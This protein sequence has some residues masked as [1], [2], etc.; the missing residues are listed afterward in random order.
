MALRQH[1]QRLLW[2]SALALLLALAQADPRD[3]TTCTSSSEQQ[4]RRL[5]PPGLQLRRG[6]GRTALSGR[7]GSSG[8]V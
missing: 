4:R 2:G 6:P 7:K 8:P 1:A 3:I 5:R